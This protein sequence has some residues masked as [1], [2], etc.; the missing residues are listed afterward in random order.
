MRKK[1]SS[2]LALIMV[3]TMLCGSAFAAETHTQK[4]SQTLKSG[5][6]VDMTCTTEHYLGE[7][8]LK[9][10]VRDN[11]TNTIDSKE[12]TLSVILLPDSGG[13]FFSAI[14]NTAFSNGQWANNDSVGCTPMTFDIENNCFY[15][16]SL[17]G[18]F[19]AD[20]K[21]LTCSYTFDDSLSAGGWNTLYCEFYPNPANNNDFNSTTDEYATVSKDFLILSQA[22]VKEF[23]STGKVFG[24][25]WPGL[26]ELLN[27]ATA[28][29][30]ATATA[31]PTTSTV[32]VN[33]TKTGFTAYNINGNNYFKLRDI[34]KVV[35]GSEKQFEVAWDGT[36]NAINL[37]SGK[38]YTAVGGELALPSS[39]DN[40]T[41]S[42]TSSTIYKDGKTVALTAYNI[43]GNNYFKL[44]DLGSTFNFGVTWD[45]T[46]NTVAIVTSAGYTPDK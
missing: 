9:L 42:M 30:P 16:E 32:T 33:G 5:T 34:A 26:K 39:T 40:Q 44:R 37:V 23:L 24:N 1:L 22:N 2:M 13:T 21:G 41:A 46:T 17:C 8:S 45:G 3:A 38:A 27:N 14:L 31:V 28:T 36:K 29:T 4:I 10:P 43:N 6:K 12:R 20:T 11:E 35:S 18:G 7:L 25:S 15:R 19:D